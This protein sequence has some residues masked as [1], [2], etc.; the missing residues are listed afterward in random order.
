MTRQHGGP[1]GGTGSAAVL[2]AA[3]V[4]LAVLICLAL[5]QWFGRM[6]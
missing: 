3:A 2:V 5:V 1:P 6:A 4:A